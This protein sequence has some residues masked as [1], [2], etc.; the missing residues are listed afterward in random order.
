MILNINIALAYTTCFEA[1]ILNVQLKWTGH[2]IHTNE[3]DMPWKMFYGEMEQG[4][5]A[6]GHLRNRNILQPFELGPVATD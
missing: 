2:V 6:K 1:N 5:H 3:S 4:T